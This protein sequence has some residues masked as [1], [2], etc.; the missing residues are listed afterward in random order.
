MMNI[1]TA[2]QYYQLTKRNHNALMRAIHERWGWMQFERRI[3]D[4]F[5]GKAYW[6][7]GARKRSKRYR[8]RKLKMYGHDKPNVLSG[9]MQKSLVATVTATPD[10][11][12]L[13]I[14]ASVADKMS[15][16]EFA[17]LSRVEQRAETRRRRYGGL[18]KWQK[19]EIAR[20]TPEEREKDRRM[21]AREYV[22]GATSKKYKR[23]RK[24]KST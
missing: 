13:K 2:I 17:K 9:R 12:R 24:R 1:V 19:E 20:V 15:P 4:H 21:Q 23:L 7:Y 16:E 14:K 22:K 18:K 8:E 6:K 5:D 11:C 10:G 3:P